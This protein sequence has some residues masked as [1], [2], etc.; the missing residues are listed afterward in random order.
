MLRQ[1][2]SE[3]KSKDVGVSTKNERGR[4]S[5]CCR[6][7]RGLDKICH[8]RP[9]HLPYCRDSEKKS[10][11]GIRKAKAY[12]PLNYTW[13]ILSDFDG[14]SKLFWT[15]WDPPP[16][17]CRRNT[18]K[19]STISSNLQSMS[20]LLRCY[21]ILIYIM[22]NILVWLIACIFIISQ[23]GLPIGLHMSFSLCCSCG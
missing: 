12:S 22:P 20:S 11:Q 3:Q 4:W 21:H 13:V 2:G 8:I 7:W 18:R 15:Q 10:V 17:N 1:S 14:V 19:K 23:F 6:I 16:Q 9:N 5:W